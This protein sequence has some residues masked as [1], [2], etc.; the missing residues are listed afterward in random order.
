MSSPEPENPYQSPAAEEPHAESSGVTI[1]AS[2]TLTRDDL[3]TI[4]RALAYNPRTITALLF[5]SIAFFAV[6]LFPFDS[7][8]RLLT[9][10]ICLIAF[11][12]LAVLFL[13]SLYYLQPYWRTQRANMGTTPQPLQYRLDDAGLQIEWGGNQS[14]IPWSSFTR[15]QASGELLIL[16]MAPNG[17]VALPAH[18]FATRDEFLAARGLIR[19]RL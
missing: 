17:W 2:G 13:E 19:Q 10:V 4:Y 8:R 3:K 7:L 11:L 15:L 9:G 12:L 18:F 6:F 16:Y 14:Q 1:V 5:F